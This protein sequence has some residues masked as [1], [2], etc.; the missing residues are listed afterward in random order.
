MTTLLAALHTALSCYSELSSNMYSRS[1]EERI[2]NRGANGKIS[3]IAIV[4]NLCSQERDDVPTRKFTVIRY[5]GQ[6]SAH[7]L[8]PFRLSI[9]EP[10][11]AAGLAHL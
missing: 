7:F 9:T 8:P 3:K 5:G 2:S 11:I 4:A 10:I 6:N 1:N